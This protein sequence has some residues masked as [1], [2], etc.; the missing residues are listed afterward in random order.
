MSEIDFAA[1][2]FAGRVFAITGSNGKTTSTMLAEAVLREAGFD[3]RACGNM[4]YPFS[5]LVLEHPECQ[6]AVA[7]LSSYQLELSSRMRVDAGLLLNLSEDHLDRHGS[8]QAYLQAKLRLVGM[9]QDGG[10]LVVNGDDDALMEGLS[11]LECAPLAFSV[12]HTAAIHLCGDTVCFPLAACDD[13]LKGQSPRLRGQHNLQNIMAVALAAFKCGV[14]VDVIRRAVLA[15]APVEHRIESV[16]VLDGVEW[17]NDS[18]A[19]NVDSTKHAL[20]CFPDRSVLLLAG[21]MAKTSDY[22]EVASELSAKA[23]VLITY[24]EDGDLIADWFAAHGRSDLLILRGAT[25]EDAVLLAR[26]TAQKGEFVLLSPMCASFDQ[27][28]NFEERGTGFKELV[29]RLQKEAQ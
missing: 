22:T 18:K 17:I 5:R 10:A 13:L 1:R 7:E 21:G 2:C 11:H 20:R 8:M 3:A 14:P 4:G 26:D 6:W 16:A 9:I 29:I 27:F 28:V 15:F 23:R 25:L 12:I 24:G 19:T